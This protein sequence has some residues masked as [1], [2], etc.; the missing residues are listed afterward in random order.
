[1]PLA[2]YLFYFFSYLISLV[3][4]KNTVFNVYSKKIPKNIGLKENWATAFAE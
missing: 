4:A 2:T 1:M 3:G